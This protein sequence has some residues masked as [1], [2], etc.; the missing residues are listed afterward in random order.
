[1]GDGD[2]DDGSDDDDDGDDGDVDGDDDND[3]DGYEKDG[4]DGSAGDD[5]VH[6]GDGVGE[7]MRIQAWS[8]CATTRGPPSAHRTG[9]SSTCVNLGVN[10]NAVTLTGSCQQQI[11]VDDTI[12][13]QLTVDSLIENTCLVSQ[14]LPTPKVLALQSQA[15][16]RVQPLVLV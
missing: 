16:F 15:W 10:L 13:S 2:D 9:A 3:D 12:C 14:S 1:M 5:A 4:K 6:T 11:T 8:G 7:S